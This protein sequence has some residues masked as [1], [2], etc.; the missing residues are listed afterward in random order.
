MTVHA[1]AGGTYRELQTPAHLGQLRSMAWKCIAGTD[2]QDPIWI[3][4]CREYWERHE[5]TYGLRMTNFTIMVE[6][7]GYLGTDVLVTYAAVQEVLP[8]TR[9]PYDAKAH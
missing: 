4:R 7:D 9:I 2:P 8:G 1:Q 3:K 6:P 5:Q